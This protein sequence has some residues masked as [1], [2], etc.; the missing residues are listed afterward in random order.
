MSRSF[1]TY[2]S[3]KTIQILMWRRFGLWLWVTVCLRVFSAVPD[4]FEKA[5]ELHS[6]ASTLFTSVFHRKKRFHPRIINWPFLNLFICWQSWSCSINISCCFPL[7]RSAHAPLCSSRSWRWWR[8]EGLSALFKVWYV[9]EN[10]D[11]HR[12]KVTNLRL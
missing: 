12:D 2:L 5:C 7:F 6:D 1:L 3:C 10:T 8:T 11:Q 9:G 4:V